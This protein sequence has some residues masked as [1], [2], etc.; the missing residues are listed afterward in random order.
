MV[1][2]WQLN[3]STSIPRQRG[4]RTWKEL[5]YFQCLFLL[6]YSGSG[7]FSSMVGAGVGD[8]GG[9]SFVLLDFLDFFFFFF[10]A[11]VEVGGGVVILVASSPARDGDGGGVKV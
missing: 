1:P 8:D 10:F 3:I 11:E 6:I 9:T 2:G 7:W 4:E 5:M